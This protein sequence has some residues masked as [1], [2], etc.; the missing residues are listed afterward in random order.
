MNAGTSPQTFQVDLPGGNWGKI[1][2]GDAIHPNGLPGSRTVP[3]GQQV[4]IQV[5]PQTAWIYRNGF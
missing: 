3:G 1:G 4:T 2:N 5:P